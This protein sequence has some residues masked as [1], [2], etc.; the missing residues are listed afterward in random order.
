MLYEVIT[1][2]P[3][4]D[5]N[6]LPFSAF[7][8]GYVDT[9][10]PFGSNTPYN[11]DVVALTNIVGETEGL[12]RTLATVGNVIGREDNTCTTKYLRI[13]SYNVCYTKLLRIY[14]PFYGRGYPD[15]LHVP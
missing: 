11:P 2:W 5:S 3:S 9:P 13:T 10:M 14:N 4:R 8:P 12:N 1:E 6:A 15:S 7:N